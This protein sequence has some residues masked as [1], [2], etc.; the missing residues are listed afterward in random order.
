ML[1]FPLPKG[2]V[3]TSAPPPTLLAPPPRA[4]SHSS[5]SVT[6]PQPRQSLC[7]SEVLLLILSPLSGWD[8]PLPCPLFQVKQMSGSFA[9]SSPPWLC[10]RHSWSSPS[11]RT[12]DIYI[13]ARQD[14]IVV[15]SDFAN[16]RLCPASETGSGGQS[17]FSSF[18]LSH[19]RIPTYL[20]SACGHLMKYRLKFKAAYFVEEIRT[21]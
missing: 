21:A 12:L 17:L 19:S 5:P 7:S 16:H 9:G 10:C 14:V 11:R 18:P 4:N 3:N 15:P 1:L 13:P 6:A 20:S 8:G 2:S